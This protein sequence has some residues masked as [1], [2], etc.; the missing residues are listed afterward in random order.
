MRRSVQAVVQ[1]IDEENHREYLHWHREG[2]R[3]QR[4]DG[5][6]QCPRGRDQREGKRDDDEDGECQLDDGHEQ[7]IV[8]D[9][10]LIRPPPD[11]VGKAELEEADQRGGEKHGNVGSQLQ[12]RA[13]PYHG[14]VQRN[15]ENQQRRKPHAGEQFLQSF[16]SRFHRGYS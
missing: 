4:R 12:R 11:L 9:V 10:G 5:Q 6:F 8:A 14:D 15:C 16:D 13:V 3:P 2:M 7:E 1:E